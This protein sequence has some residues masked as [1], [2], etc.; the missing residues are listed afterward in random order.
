MK[1]KMKVFG[2]TL[3]MMAM[4]FSF[5][6]GTPSYGQTGIPGEPHHIC[7]QSNSSG[8]TDLG[9]MHWETDE[10]RFAVTCTD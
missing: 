9:G 1:I 2:L 6:V 10:V 7:C 5:F 8:C 4:A 3:G